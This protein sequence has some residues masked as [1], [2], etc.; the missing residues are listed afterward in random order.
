M[1]C[2]SAIDSLRCTSDKKCLGLSTVQLLAIEH[3]NGKILQNIG[4]VHQQKLRGIASRA[5]VIWLQGVC[6][7]LL[8]LHGISSCVQVHTTP[9]QSRN[10]SA[11]KSEVLAELLRIVDRS[12]ARLAYPTTTTQ[13]MP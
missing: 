3:K 13:P 12:G 4:R 10:Y 6:R 8:L 7:R 9:K 5:S 2:K 11:F 1:S